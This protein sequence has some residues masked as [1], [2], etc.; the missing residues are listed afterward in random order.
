MFEEILLY[1]KN[2]SGIKSN[3]G[4]GSAYLIGTLAGHAI[5]TGNHEATRKFILKLVIDACVEP[6][7]HGNLL[8][9]R[10]ILARKEAW[11]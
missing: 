3:Y 7:R 6:E 2:V 11:F 8:L 1:K 10:R 5:A 9:R 4:K